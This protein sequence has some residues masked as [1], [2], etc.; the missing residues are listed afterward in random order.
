M[1]L[2]QKLAVFLRLFTG[3]AIFG[4]AGLLG[5]S[6]RSP[7][8]I[9]WLG[10]I[11]TLLYV[12]GKWSKWKALWHSQSIV[13]WLKA[14]AMTLPAQLVLAAVVYLLG[15]GLGHLFG[16]GRLAHQL[17]RFDA[18]VLITITGLG[19]ALS[20]LIHY[21]EGGRGAETLIVENMTKKAIGDAQAY[22]R[23]ETPEEDDFVVLAEVITVDKLLS[24]YRQEADYSLAA[25]K[26]DQDDSRSRQI[27]APVGA[28][29]QAI[30]HTEQRLG[31]VLPKT[32][33][34]IYR[35]KN[36]GGVHSVYVPKVAQPKSTY[37]DWEN[38]F[39]GYESLYSLD[40]LRTVHDSTLDFTCED[41][42]E[43]F[44][45]GA[46]QFLILAQW[47]RQTTFLDYRLCSGRQGVEP[48]VGIVDFDK[49]NW[50]ADG[51]WF[52][53]F[54]SFFS[55][56]RRVEHDFDRPPPSAPLDTFAPSAEKADAFWQWSV[57]AATSSA[58]EVSWQKA[59]NR[60]GK[61][62]PVE[63]RPYME[64]VN[65]GLVYYQYLPL[66][67]GDR[68]YP[69]PGAYLMGVD[70]WLSLQDLS[71]RLEFV[72][73]QIPWAQSWPSS[74]DI[75]VISASY[76][77]ALLL[78]YRSDLQQPRVL[79]TT[80][81][82]I[83]EQA[84]DLGNVEQFL[85]SLRAERK[86]HWSFSPIGDVRLSARRSSAAAFW[87][88]GDNG[89]GLSQEQVEV[90]Q[91]RLGMRLPQTV[92]DCMK[93]SNGGAVRFRYQPPLAPNAAAYLNPVPLAPEWIDLFPNPVL[94]M[95]R[96]QR[97]SEWN[98]AHAE[99]FGDAL[100][101][102]GYSQYVGDDF[103]DPERVLVIAEGQNYLNLIDFSRENNPDNAHLV[104]LHK[105]P[106]GWREAY[107]AVG[108]RGA[109]LRARRDEL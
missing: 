36:G 53:S 103:G 58:D 81:L 83:P 17:G 60:L 44:P 66:P 99:D 48:R 18:V 10:G 8:V 32:L 51:L 95:A 19:L 50:E 102:K 54:D 68:L 22:H 88:E 62:L 92:T 55:A 75:L 27:K 93:V 13:G 104:L 96:W 101:Q 69:F 87:V 2:P 41:D 84:L 29:D 25:L 31:F 105:E 76:D 73:S 20:V 100:R 21:L 71:D 42:A 94:P 12:A 63:L 91:E 15:L 45:A 46:K 82:D 59:Q 64:A 11:F 40:K 79:Y 6:Q 85:L 9:F 4:G 37:E 67:S 30:A 98:R 72:D 90:A 107:R 1:T 78:D 86:P 49:E 61:T 74:Q 14:L 77:R 33:K 70:Y 34:Q 39:G 109:G 38:A 57:L 106:V 16:E 23:Q 47:Y 43:S 108:I 24:V 3:P 52:D 56:L 35:R 28:S 5:F 65:G 7:V 26:C 97:L 89:S 80:N